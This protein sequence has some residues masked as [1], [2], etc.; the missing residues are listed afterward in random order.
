MLD[1][2]FHFESHWE[3]LEA[4]AKMGFKVNPHRKKLAGLDEVLDFYRHWE[5]QRETL[6]YE[7]DGLVV[8]GDSV[9]QQKSLGWTAKAPRWAIAFKF[10]AQQPET[11][12]EDI[13][14]SVGR[15]GALTPGAFPREVNIPG[16]TG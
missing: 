4:L 9:P 2:Q 11:D 5:A 16:V 7:I 8:K 10:A 14:R 13:N 12:V 15:T 6:P 3:S 1:G